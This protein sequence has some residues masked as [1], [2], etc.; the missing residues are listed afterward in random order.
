MTVVGAGVMAVE[1]L[2]PDWEFDRVDDG[3]QSKGAAG[4]GL[5]VDSHRPA[6][7]RAALL[8]EGFA[9]RWA[10]SFLRLGV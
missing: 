6:D 9:L 5:R 10:R 1:T 4:R 8:R 3:S 7:V 2:S